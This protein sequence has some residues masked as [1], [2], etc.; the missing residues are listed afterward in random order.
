MKQLKDLSLSLNW[1]DFV[2]SFA[3]ER[4]HSVKIRKG[5]ESVGPQDA[6]AHEFREMCSR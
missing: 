3:A 1:K 6:V 4:I 5:C 2:V